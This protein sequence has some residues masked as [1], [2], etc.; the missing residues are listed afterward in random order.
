M[1]DRP[2]APGR[3]EVAQAFLNTNDLEARVDELSS[4]EALASWLVDHDL[5]EPGT[6][7]D[8]DDLA[9]AVQVREALRDLLESHHATPPH[10]PAVGV[11]EAVAGAAQLVTRFEP[12][13]AG[14]LEATA[15]GLTGALGNILAIVHTAMADGSWYRM[16]VCQRDSCRW[17]FYDHSKNRSS[18]WCSMASCGNKA[19]AAAYRS[20]QTT[21]IHR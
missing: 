11:L 16:K 8:A 9:H 5:L 20:R 15:D 14:R 21:P 12:G 18:T 19:K 6:S 17:A 4:P 13:G 3:L 7:L 10:P 1:T 2:P